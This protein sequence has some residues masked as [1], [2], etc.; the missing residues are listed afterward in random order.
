MMNGSIN[1]PLLLK[2]LI[3]GIFAVTR[4]RMGNGVTMVSVK[5]NVRIQA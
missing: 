2:T 3:G 4:C 5:Y 1:I